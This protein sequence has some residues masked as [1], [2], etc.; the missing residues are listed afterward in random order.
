MQQKS[1]FQSVLMTMKSYVYGAMETHLIEKELEISW[2]V[3][4]D[5]LQILMVVVYGFLTELH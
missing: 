5:T 1:N 4:M 2:F 3:T